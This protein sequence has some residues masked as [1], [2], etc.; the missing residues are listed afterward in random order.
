MQNVV[1]AALF[2][3]LAGLS[4][5]AVCGA[6]LIGPVTPAEGTTV[7]TFSFG[8]SIEIGATTDPSTLRVPLNG[9]DIV[10]PLGGGPPTYMATMNP[11]APLL[12]SNILVVHVSESDGNRA[13][14][15]DEDHPLRLPAA[16]GEREGRGEPVGLSDRPARPLPTR[17]LHARQHRRA[18]RRPEGAQRELH[19]TGTFGGNLID[20]ETVVG[21]V[22]QG[23]DNFFEFQPMV[24]IEQAINAPDVEIVNDGQDGTAAIVRTCGPDDLL[25]DINPSSQVALLGAIFPARRRR[26]RL[27]RDRL[28]RVS[29]R[30]ADPHGGAETSIENLSNVEDRLDLFIGD[31]VNGRTGRTVDA[32]LADAAR[33]ADPQRRRR[34]DARQLRHPRDRLLRLRRSRG[35]RLHARCSPNVPEVLGTEQLVHGERRLARAARQHDPV[36]SCSAAFPASTCW[37]ARRNS[38]RRWFEVGDGSA[39]NG[40]ESMVDVLGMANGTLRGCVREAVSNAPI[41]GA[42]VA[43]R[44]S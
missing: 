1:R 20:A 31:F 9:D 12:D 15:C 25:D 11:G 24:N 7:S 28:H 41:A 8:I 43:A 22:P 44:E 32:G 33:D 37:P 13:D 18:L 19:F 36:Q 42:R 39:A 23:R 34:R 14:R 38:F 5:G 26:R 10:G 17:R 6:P 29:P 35:R 27:R 21:G 4:M 2:L 16:E 30:S 3:G 40:I